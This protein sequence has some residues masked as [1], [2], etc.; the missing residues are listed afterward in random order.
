MLS[1]DSP[2]VVSK[3]YSAQENRQVLTKTLA[4]GAIAL[5]GGGVLWWYLDPVGFAQS[6]PMQM[7]SSA[8]RNSGSRFSR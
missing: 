3:A 8:G 6:A 7:L 4:W 1:P 5:V 2:T